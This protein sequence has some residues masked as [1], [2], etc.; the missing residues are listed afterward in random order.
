M[1]LPTTYSSVFQPQG[2]LP[3]IV[4]GGFLCVRSEEDGPLRVFCIFYF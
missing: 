3:T 2:I 1:R 4:I